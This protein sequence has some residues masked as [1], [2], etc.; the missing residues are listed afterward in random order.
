MSGTA[1]P[2]STAN[3]SLPRPCKSWSSSRRVPGNVTRALDFLLGD[4]WL[5]PALFPTN[6]TRAA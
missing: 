2:T 4:Y 5:V 1:A 6:W 3:P